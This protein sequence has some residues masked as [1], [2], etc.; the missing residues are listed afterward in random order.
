MLERLR[1]AVVALAVAL[2]LACGESR[3]PAPPT[4]PTTPPPPP[5]RPVL[6]APEADAVIPQNNPASG[7]AFHP[8]AGAG[9]RIAF[10]WVDVTAPAG[11]AGYEIYAQGDRATI[12]IVNSSTQSSEYVHI[13]CGAYVVDP[14]LQGWVWRVRAVDRNGQFSEWAERRFSYAP[15]RIGGRPCGS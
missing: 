15:C 2:A 14:N 7:C 9:I 4:L 3:T 10:D 13:A 1:S 11:L 5:S 6:L 12:P 8:S